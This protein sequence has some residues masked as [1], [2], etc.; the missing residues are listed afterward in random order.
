MVATRRGPCL[1]PSIKKEETVLQSE[2][3]PT[4][5]IT[6]RRTVTMANKSPSKQTSGSQQDNAEGQSR[7][8][9]EPSSTPKR[10]TRSSKCAPTDSNHEADVSDSESCCSV[11]SGV[12]AVAA[13]KPTPRTR[14][15][16]AAQATPASA[17][18]R[19]ASE[20]ESCS[21]DPVSKPSR[22]TR[23][24]KK[25]TS[26]LAESTNS[27][28]IRESEAESCS[29]VVS[30]SKGVD[31][32]MITR[33]RR[34]TAV[35][36]DV[37]NPLQADSS[38]SAVSGPQGSSLRRSA[39]IRR[40]RPVEPIPIHLEQ[41]ETT[42]ASDSSGPSRTLRH[43]SKA[44]TTDENQPYDSEGCRSGPSTS[45]WRN[46]RSGG[47]VVDSDL[48]SSLD[49]PCSPKGKG[50]PCRSRMGTASSNR[51]ASA[52]TRCKTRVLSNVLDAPSVASEDIDMESEGDPVDTPVDVPL[53]SA[54]PAMSD[55]EDAE[56]TEDKEDNKTVIGVDQEHLISEDGKGD[57]TLMFDDSA[58]GGAGA[59]MVES[60]SRHE[61]VCMEENLSTKVQEKNDDD[62]VRE[63]CETEQAQ[64]HLQ[65]S[66][67]GDTVTMTNEPE[68]KVEGTEYKSELLVGD[69]ASKADQD[70][71]ELAENGGKISEEAAEVLDGCVPQKAFADH[72]VTHS[73][74]ADQ[75]DEDEEHDM[76]KE[77]PMNV[78]TSA[79]AVSHMS[80]D[81]PKDEAVGQLQIEDEA[82]GQLQIE[83]EAVGQSQIEDEAV[84]QSQIEDE[85]VGQS[86][87]EDEAVGQSQIEDEAV[88]QSQIEDEAVGQS[89][90][91]DEAVGQSQI[92]DEAVGQSQI[93]DEAVGQ[94]QIE[95]E[96]VGQSQFAEEGPSCSSNAQKLKTTPVKGGPSLLDSSE[97][98]SEDEGCMEE[99]DEYSESDAEVVSSE[100]S[101]PG[102]SG[103]ADSPHSNS[104]FVIDARPGLQP[105]KKYYIDETPHEG[106]DHTDD[107]KADDEFV[108]DEGDD[109]DDDDEDSKALFTNRKP[110]LTELS[111]SIDPGLKVKELGGLYISFDGSKSKSI[112]N[113]LKKLKDQKNQD[114]LLKKSIIV[115]DFEKKDTVPPYKESKRAAKLKRKEERAKTTGDSWFNMRAPEMT[116][117]LR[118]D[119]KALQMRSA[120]DPKRFYKKNDRE[121]LPKY[122]Q[123]GTVVDSPVDFYH[124]RI[125]KKQR[126]K[127]IMEELLADAE[128]RSYNKR[129]Y[130]EIM[131]EKAAEAAGRIKKKKHKMNK[132]K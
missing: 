29:S 112:S 113:N 28:D 54:H 96:E 39:R 95:D 18:E 115:A 31:T 108:D 76:D 15:R 63:E 69:L 50:T 80:E 114:Q 17:A 37:A 91:E 78:D 65:C 110:A 20:E 70:P 85:A 5:R 81:W 3:T 47:R 32:R 61:T 26:V 7:A 99:E 33:S 84:G 74:V 90:I 9:S 1:S 109:D 77:Q 56:D 53:Q 21:S 121:G 30:Q 102:Q 51:T 6:R 106:E 79:D 38:S 117:E 57:D 8:L 92:E 93:E 14:R 73:D 130:Q 25:P 72:T 94:S 88:G 105:C 55:G 111:S 60:E 52:S 48:D 120:M 43:R 4:T 49:S 66:Q 104:L 125:P 119:L 67:S 24:Q 132:K 122:F 89:Q 16:A 107:F 131:S 118:N 129:K 101:Q 86:Q 127:T 11:A 71:S 128:F 124:S 12:L 83:D 42:E 62:D 59:E 123:V 75:K 22:S 45:P 10:H 87:I 97:D 103:E 44:R 2:A 35:L 98:E 23:S 58:S 34:R 46:T 64:P 40:T 116:E 82:V 126:K 36:P 27:R 68:D 13:T 100:E 41:G 19:D